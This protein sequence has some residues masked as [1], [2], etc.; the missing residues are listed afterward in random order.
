MNQITVTMKTILM[1]YLKHHSG[2]PIS[3]SQGGRHLG[4]RLL[5]AQGVESGVESGSRE[6]GQLGGGSRARC[7]EG[8]AR[9]LTPQLALS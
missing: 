5:L 4:F 2:I 7:R 3:H 9:P 8:G 6:E 1:S